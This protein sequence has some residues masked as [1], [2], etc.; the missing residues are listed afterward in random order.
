VSNKDKTP[1]PTHRINDPV[2]LSRRISGTRKKLTEQK[3]PKKA[4]GT[5]LSA[6]CHHRVESESNEKILRHQ[7]ELIKRCPLKGKD[8]LLVMDDEE[9]IRLVVGKML[10]EIGY[11]ADFAEDGE[12]ALEKYEGAMKAI[13]LEQSLWI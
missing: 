6:V 12:N 13:L 3:K 11:D 2:S 5:G 9:I 8:R 10:Q 4:P 1:L 7:I